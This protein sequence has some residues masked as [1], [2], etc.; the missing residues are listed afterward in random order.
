M[1]LCKVSGEEAGSFCKG[2]RMYGRGLR[3]RNRSARAKHWVME[4]RFALLLLL[5]L[6]P[7]PSGLEETRDF[8]LWGPVNQKPPPPCNLPKALLPTAGL[9]P[10]L[11][12]HCHPVGRA[13]HSS[14]APERR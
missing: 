11:S 10:W 14:P 2:V 13:Q 7:I 1:T 5:L 12:G 3:P 4:N 8:A 9:S 6:L